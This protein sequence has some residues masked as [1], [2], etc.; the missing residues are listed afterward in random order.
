MDYAPPFQMGHP[1]A[2]RLANELVQLAPDGARVIDAEGGPG[3]P[4]AA[5]ERQFPILVGG[6]A[7]RAGP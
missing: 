7:P 3:T 5:P 1:S 6:R 2:F 4:C